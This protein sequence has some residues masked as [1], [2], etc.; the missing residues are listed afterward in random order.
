MAAAHDGDRGHRGG[1]GFAP[2]AASAYG[3]TEDQKTPFVVPQGYTQRVISDESD[4]DLYTSICPGLPGILTLNPKSDWPDMTVANE[5]GKRAGRYLY[6]THEVR[7]FLYDPACTFGVVPQSAK[8]AYVADGGGAL[9]VIDTKKGTTK[10]LAQRG[11]W[12]ALDGLLWSPWGTLLFAE[13]TLTTELPDPNAPQAQSGLLYEL[14]LD[15]KD[16]SKSA[17]VAV[18]PKLGALA[19]EGI[20]SD[21][22]GNIYVIDEDRRGAIY[23]FVPKSYGD[24]SDG[25]LQ[26]LKVDAGKTGTAKW[27]DLDMAQVQNSARVAAAAVGG[28]QFCRPEDLERIKNVM[29]A[30]LTCEDV[31]NPANLNGPGAILSVTLGD[32]P[33]VGYFV[34][35]GINV[36]PEDRAA[37]VTG[38]RAPDNLANGPGGKLWISED[39]TF[40]DIWVAGRDRDGDGDADSVSHFGSLKDPNAE[41]TGIYFGKDPRVLY[42]NIQHASSGNDSTVAIARAKRD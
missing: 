20:E 34:A 42:V 36:G 37:G 8:D 28:T 32:T 15:P 12:D 18:R 41:A 29:Y 23:R 21:R 24:L 2:I 6:R 14:E 22:A 3:Q 38:F 26:V 27:I 11:D 19:H 16:P 5:T 35:P 4:L 40:S 9:S 33:K 7:P 17:G 30:A 25:Q 39:N 13:E 31:T 10:V 1:F